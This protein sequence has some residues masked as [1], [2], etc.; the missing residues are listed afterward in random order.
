VPMDA[1]SIREAVEKEEADELAESL[2]LSSYD[3]NTISTTTNDNTTP[4]RQMNL[5][6]TRIIVK[7]MDHF[8]RDH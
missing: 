2:V 4:N 6:S 5:V 3:S 7:Y 8:H 1:A